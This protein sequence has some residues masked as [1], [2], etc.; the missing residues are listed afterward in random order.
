MKN[1]A[2]HT[3]GSTSKLMHVTDAGLKELHHLKQL[4]LLYVVAT[5]V[6][7]DGMKTLEAAL[8]RCK[9]VHQ[10]ERYGESFSSCLAVVESIAAVCVIDLLRGISPSPFGAA[11]RLMRAL[12]LVECVDSDFIP[13][14]QRL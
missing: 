9:I 14:T 5:D 12:D 8:P 7:A 3:A 10:I 1:S 2:Q 4:R 11:D 13:S 6:T